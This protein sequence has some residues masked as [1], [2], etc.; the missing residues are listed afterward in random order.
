MDAI[1]LAG[2]Y[3]T[4][5]YPLTKDRPKALL[6]VAGRAILDHVADRLDAA[7]EIARM[8]LVTN[9]KFAG[10][11][12]QWAARRKL[13]TPLQ[14]LNDGTSSNETRLGAI[15][16]I[17]FVLDNAEVDTSEGLFVLGTDNLAEFDILQVVRFARERGTSA[18]FAV[19]EHDSERLLRMGVVLLDGND[20]VVDFEEK[21]AE[22]KSDLVVPPFYVYSPEAVAL[23]SRYL[24]EGQ[25]P[26]A[27][28][29]FIEWLVHQCPV[30]ACVTEGIV[31]DI[32]TP[33]SYEAVRRV[34]E[35]KG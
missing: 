35:G 33:Q 14:V 6:P 13:N 23:L 27:P 20:R 2:G 8:F 16:D 10:H 5:L 28:G 1:L 15:G 24:A 21:P 26:D 3:A 29:H 7:D 17:R 18:V 22:P 34:Y 12:D 9:A 32:G 30:H 19:R 25:N 4:R 11:F 31:R